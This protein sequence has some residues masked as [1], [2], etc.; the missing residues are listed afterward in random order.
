M[1]QSTFDG[2]EFSFGQVTLTVQISE[3]QKHFVVLR[4]RILIFQKPRPDPCDQPN[5]NRN[6]DNQP[7]P[8]ECRRLK[9]LSEQ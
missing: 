5:Q 1:C 8:I 2:S 6:R 4:G 3:L 9:R 7:D